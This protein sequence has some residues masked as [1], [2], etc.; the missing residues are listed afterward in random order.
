MSSN[1]LTYALKGD[2]RESEGPNAQPNNVPL[3]PDLH[4]PCDAEFRK[5]LPYWRS[6]WCLGIVV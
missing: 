5:S 1:P 2:H 6:Y 4:R 3:S